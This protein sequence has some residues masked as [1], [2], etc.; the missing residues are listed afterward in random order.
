MTSDSCPL[1]YANYREWG[2][3]NYASTE[4]GALRALRAVEL[5]E[6]EAEL[7]AEGLVEASNYA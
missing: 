7:E 5:Y 3:L 1:I 2:L 6:P 4:S